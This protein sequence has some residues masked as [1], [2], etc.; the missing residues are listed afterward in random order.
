MR[1]TESLRAD[2]L[3]E[4]KNRRWK[5][6]LKRLQW[7][8]RNHSGVG[9]LVGQVNSRRRYL[10]RPSVLENILKKHKTEQNSG[11]RIHGG[12]PP[13]TTTWQT[14]TT[15]TQRVP[16]Q[17]QAGRIS[18]RETSELPPL[19]ATRSVS[20]YADLICLLSVVMCTREILTPF[21]GY[22]L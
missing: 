11:A 8:V 9:V 7:P 19:P 16:V 14:A 22:F 20:L 15:L 5:R 21:C 3:Q 4:S 6:K 1:R 18:L 17:K 13:E 12:L 2:G 10:T